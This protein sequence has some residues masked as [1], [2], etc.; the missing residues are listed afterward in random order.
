MRIALAQLGSVPGRFH[1]TVDR[2]LGAAHR[3][4]RRGADLVVFP[5][6]LLCGVYPLGIGESRAFML[7]MLAAI[8]E[9]AS[10]TPVPAAVP[11]Y[12]FDGECGYTEVFMCID[13]TVCPLRLREV[14]RPGSSCT[15]PAEA[16]ATFT[17]AGCEVQFM[18]GDSA[19]VVSE[20]ACDVLVAVSPMPFCDGDATSLGVAGLSDGG[21]AGMVSESPCWFAYLQ[22]VGG[23]DDAV[24]AGGSFAATPEGVVAA[25][26]PMFEEG[27]ATFDV[28]RR[29]EEAPAVDV[30]ALP[31]TPVGLPVAEAPTLSDEERTGYLYRALTVAVRDYVR[32]SGFSDVVVG[33]S[34]GIDSAVVAALAADALGPEHVTGVLMPGPY[35]SPSSVTDATELAARLGIET[36]TAP[37]AGLFDVLGTVFGEAFGEELA[38]LARENAQARLR[39]LILMSLANARGSLV[40]NTG[41]KSEAGMGYSTLYGDTVGAYAPLADCY[42]GRVYDLA[43]WRNGR[44]PVAPIPQEIIDKAPSAELSEDQTDEGSLGMGYGD[45]DR[46]LYMHVERGLD[47]R[48]IVRAGFDAD[49]VEKVLSA[50]RR[51]EFKRRQEPLGATVSIRP[52]IDRGWPIVLGWDDK[53]PDVQGAGVAC[54][55]CGCPGCAEGGEE[56]DDLIDAIVDEEPSVA[57]ALMGMLAGAARQDQVMGMLGDVAFGRIVAGSGPDMD[58]YMGIPLFSKN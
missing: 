29:S 19:F 6:T 15:S 32:K 26:C 5:P 18:A 34:G 40:L 37:I 23:Y 36:Y 46:I 17:V 1:E 9:F 10:S 12:V 31:G 25:A 44:G 33:L 47:A 50:A 52:F 51:F 4:A 58:S 45:I 43:A 8:E 24:L 56:E 30:V 39:G 11:A 7:D 42:K 22:G 3:A 48:D 28:P 13:G 20:A 16:P 55:P 57:D 41:N 21:F 14:H 53:A 49:K 35:S 27:L 38:G 2:M 54:G